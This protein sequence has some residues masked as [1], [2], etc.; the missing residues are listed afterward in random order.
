M[1]RCLTFAGGSES[2]GV[3]SVVVDDLVFLLGT[4]CML[5]SVKA[6]QRRVLLVAPIV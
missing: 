3:D 4:A 6:A 5:W 2:R 1:I